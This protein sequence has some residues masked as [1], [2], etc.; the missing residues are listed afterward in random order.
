MVQRLGL[1]GREGDVGALSGHEAPLVV[2]MHERP[3]PIDHRS[4]SDEKDQDHHERAH[5]ERPA[6]R[7]AT[8]HG[9]RGVTAVWRGKQTRS[10]ARRH[11]GYLPR[12][13]GGT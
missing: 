11:R 7:D 12:L 2:C 9:S 6:P 10:T 1:N 13:T 3:D 8:A 5:D 4:H